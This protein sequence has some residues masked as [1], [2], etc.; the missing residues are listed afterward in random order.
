MSLRPLALVVLAFL[1]WG[2]P[3][4][5]ARRIEPP[6]EYAKYYEEEPTVEL[7]TMGIGALCLRFH[8]PREDRCYNYG[9]A[10]FQKPLSMAA[11]FFRGARSFWVGAQSPAMMLAIYTHADRT[12]WVQPLPLTPEQKQ[13]VIA[14]LESDDTDEHRYYAYDHFLDN[15]TTRVRDVI[16]DA[17]G[18]ALRSMNQRRCVMLHPIPAPTSIKPLAAKAALAWAPTASYKPIVTSRPTRART[19]GCRVADQVN[20]SERWA[21]VA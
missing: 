2:A 14:K 11:G 12:V 1:A 9:I 18:G 19:L 7:V 4:H 20:T 17:T 15:C 5:A 10:E 3:A 21:V 16:D 8:D 6:P 13:K